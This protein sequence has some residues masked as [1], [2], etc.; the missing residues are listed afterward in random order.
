MENNVV[1]SVKAVTKKFSKSIVSSSTIR[2]R[3]LNFNNRKVQKPEVIA[4]SMV[5]F[6]VNSGETFGIIGRNG[7]GKSTLIHLIM[8]SM[9]PTFG[10]IT[11]EGKLIRLS[12]GI[13][14]DENLSARDNIYVN[15]SILGLSF[16]KI[17]AIFNSI[18]EFAGLED[19]VDMRIK[20]YSNGMKARLKFAIAMYAEADIFLLDEFFGGVGDE[21]FKAKSDLAFN[22]RIIEGKTNVIVSHSMN[23]IEKYCHRVLWL[24]KGKT[25]MIGEP[26]SVIKAYKNSFK[27]K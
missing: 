7:S 4:L 19:F 6:Q 21:D 26:E 18:I 22:K 15:G 5:D 17:G 10:H 8:G 11:T 23:I 2:D 27:S 12:L 25:K 1:I 14:I 24:E 13:G 20:Q 9:M 16:K 3:I